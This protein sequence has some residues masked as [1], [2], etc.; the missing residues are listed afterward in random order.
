[1]PM[2]LRLAPADERALR[3]VA[4]HD[5]RNM[6]DEIVA[7]VRERHETVRV[8]QDRAAMRAQL[9]REF[10]RVEEEDAVALDLLS[11]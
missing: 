11:Q 2:T 6:T 3:E 7:L 10:E 4:A 8:E 5:Q 1:M 9:R